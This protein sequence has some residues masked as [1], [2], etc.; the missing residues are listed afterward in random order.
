MIPTT[1][2]SRKKIQIGIPKRFTEGGAGAHDRKEILRKRKK[3]IR[4]E[5]TK[6]TFKKVDFF[7]GSNYRF[8]K[9]L[10]LDNA[11]CPHYYTIY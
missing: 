2:F 3:G 6:T 10:E 5:T 9:Y 4:I 1:T 11:I 8:F 7:K